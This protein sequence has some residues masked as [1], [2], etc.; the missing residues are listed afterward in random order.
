MGL[1]KAFSNQVA[2]EHLFL[3][4]FER[5][6]EIALQFPSCVWG[7]G[8]GPWGGGGMGWVFVVADGVWGMCVGLWCGGVVWGCGV[9]VWC[10]VGVFMPKG[11]H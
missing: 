7:V 6:E 1:L 8:V 2:P 5:S 11:T 4:D 3:N 9:W 10:G